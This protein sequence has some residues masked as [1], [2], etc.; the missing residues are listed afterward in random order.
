MA[1]GRDERNNKKRNPV[2]VRDL[3]APNVLWA[4]FSNPSEP[5]EAVTDYVREQ[6]AARSRMNHPSNL[7]KL[8]KDEQ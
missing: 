3:N 7:P 6:G 4:N 2:I 8:P 5:H 1:R